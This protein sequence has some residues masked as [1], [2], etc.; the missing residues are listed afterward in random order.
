ML[1][2]HATTQLKIRELEGGTRTVLG[3]DGHPKIKEEKAR[4][5]RGATS[6]RVSSQNKGAPGREQR[7]GVT[8]GG[9]G[10]TWVQGR[11]GKC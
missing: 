3:T 6:T 2:Q 1:A 4:D 10:G 11:Q 5:G 9:G 7:T 8:D